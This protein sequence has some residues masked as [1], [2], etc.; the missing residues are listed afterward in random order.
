M[1]KYETK[2]FNLYFLSPGVNID[3]QKRT[4]DDAHSL[5]D[6]QAQKMKTETKTRNNRVSNLSQKV[7]AR[8]TDP[9]NNNT[10]GSELH[11]GFIGKQIGQVRGEFDNFDRLQLINQPSDMFDDT[12]PKKSK[13]KNR[14]NR[15]YMALSKSPRQLE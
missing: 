7:S 14:N 9:R 1:S 12:F 13:S 6:E 4:I 8:G 15:G 11:K 5:N 2:P 3:I 10:A